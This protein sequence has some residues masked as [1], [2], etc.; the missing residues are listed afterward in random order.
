MYEEYE[1]L[2]KSFN[3]IEA[4]ELMDMEVKEQKFIIKNLLPAGL[5]ILGGSPKIGKSWLVLKLCINIANGENFLGFQTNKGRTLYVSLEDTYSRLQKRLLSITDEVKNMS[6]S[7]FA[8]KIGEGID[9]QIK[10]QMNDYPDTVLIVIDTLQM[11]R[12]SKEVNYANDYAE[13][14]V[15]KQLAD[16]LGIAI[17]LVHHLRKLNDDDPFNML[18]GTNGIAGGVDTMFVLAKKDRTSNEAT[19]YCTGRDIEDRELKLRFNRESFTWDLVADS[20][21]NPEFFLPSEM[22]KLIEFMKI[23]QSFNGSNTDFCEQFNAFAGANFDAKTLKRRM[24]RFREELSEAGI[25]YHSSKKDGKRLLEIKYDLSKD[26][27]NKKE[28]E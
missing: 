25:S 24:N 7:N 6:I 4:E 17:L 23:K 16:E 21:E 11:I 20:I 9:S 26:I 1:I 2:K 8:Y 13:I 3:A 18:S 5:S 12:G 19:L 28:E 10:K 14:K 22:N 27:N 15:L